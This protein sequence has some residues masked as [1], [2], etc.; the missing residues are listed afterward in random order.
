MSNSPACILRPFLLIAGAI[1]LLVFSCRK[2]DEISTDSGLMLSFS[3]D[4]VV[5]DTVF[6]SLGTVTIPLKV[7]NKHDVGLRIASIS[8][9][10]GNKSAFRINVD[11]TPGL[12]FYDKE[13]APNDSIFI[14]VRATIDPRDESNPFV[15]EDDLE[16]ITNGNTQHV[17]LVAWGQDAVYILADSEI[18]GFPPFKIIAD[19]LESVVWTAEKPYVVYGY[20]VINSYGELLIEEGTRVHFHDKSGLWAFSDGVLKVR[21]TLE[22][23]VVFQGDRLDQAYRHIPGQWDRIWLMEG[24]QGFDH[25]IEYAIIRN[26]FIGLQVESFLRPTE[27]KLIIR[28]T[29]IEN[30]TGLGLFSRLA[31]IEA[32]NLV[33]ANTGNYTVALTAGGIYDFK[34]TTIAN[35]WS[36]SV[37]NNPALYVNNYLLDSLDQPVAIPFSLNMGNS[38]VYG[39][40]SEEIDIEMIEGADTT[41]LF[42]YCLLKTTKDPDNWSG[43]E[44]SITNKNPEFRNYESFNFRPDSL[45]PVIGIGSAEIA[46]SVPL[47]LDGVSRTEAADLGAYQFVPGLED[48]SI[49]H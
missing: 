9:Q 7:Y 39:S 35:N 32:E 6:S 18:S 33:V 27:N 43:F 40:N 28:N 31:H 47:D 16:F 17:K 2:H 45:S 14:F 23:P 34:H 11:G 41:Y 4:S 49:R 38:I 30:H 22:N 25:E 19:S 48:R 8:L 37:R 44:N 21:G 10:G 5:F 20:A 24:R 3:A 36:A 12:A 46:A 29:I 13:I 42:N 15:V 26:G 1:L